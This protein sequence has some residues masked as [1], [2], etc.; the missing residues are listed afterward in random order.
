MINVLE[1]EKIRQVGHVF[2]LNDEYIVC[3][4][5]L[6]PIPGGIHTLSSAAGITEKRHDDDDN[7]SQEKLN[8]YQT[9]MACSSQ[10][11]E[12]YDSD[13]DNSSH[14]DDEPLTHKDSINEHEEEHQNQ[15]IV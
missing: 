4:F 13:F 10:A 2:F 9:Q 1:K 12:N 6:H 15:L 3:F 8:D 5:L 14:E 7:N 11:N